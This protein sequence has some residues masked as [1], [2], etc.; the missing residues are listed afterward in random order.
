MSNSHPT[1]AI[2]QLLK[3]LHIVGE[4]KGF[5]ISPVGTSTVSH[6]GGFANING[7][8]QRLGIDSS[9]FFCFTFIHG[10]TPFSGF[11][12]TSLRIGQSARK[13]I[14]FFC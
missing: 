1:D 9:P 3:P 8:D 10:Y 5:T 13:S 2:P 11:N 12:R 14:A 4:F 7:N 6:G